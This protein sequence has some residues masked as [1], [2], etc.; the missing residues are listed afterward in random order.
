MVVGTIFFII[1]LILMGILFFVFWIITLVDA[2][3]RKFGKENEKLIWILVIVLTGVIGSLIYYFVVY[4]QDKTKTLKWFWWT[5]LILFIL[6][7]VSFISLFF[8]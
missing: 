1:S 8:V 6:L 2:I 5:A 7:I 3:K 4:K